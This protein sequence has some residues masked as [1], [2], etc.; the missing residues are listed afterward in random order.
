M[1]RE[2]GYE[3][4]LTSVAAL[5]ALTPAVWGTTYIVATEFLPEGRPM[6]AATLRALPVGLAFVLW[7]RKLPQGS[8]WWRSVLLGF[9]N[10]GAFFALLFVAA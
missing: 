4:S 8:W 3:P 7:S 10:I 6:F 2:P 1:S 9:L 5:T